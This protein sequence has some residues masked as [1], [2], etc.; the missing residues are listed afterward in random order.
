MISSCLFDFYCT[1]VNFFFFFRP[2][3]LKVWLSLQEFSN[4]VVFLTWLRTEA[5]HLCKYRNNHCCFVLLKD[6]E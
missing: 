3:R 4:A 6:T 1:S 2:L 5:R